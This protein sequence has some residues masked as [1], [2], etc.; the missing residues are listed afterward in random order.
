MDVD[1]FLHDLQA[2]P[3]YAG[4][5]VRVYRQEPRTTRLAATPPEFAPLLER[6]GMDALYSHQAEALAQVLAGRDLVIATGTASGKSLCYQLPLLRELARDPH[7]SA[8]L[9]F[10]T[11]ALCQDQFRAFA[12]L[13]DRAGTA[14]LAGVIDG[15]TPAEL[16]RK[17]RD[18]GRVLFSNPDML[19]AAIMPQH[20]RWARFLGQLRL[21]VLDEL[22]VYN[23][24]FGA[25]MA[26]L[27][28]RLFRLCRH[29]GA[30]PRLIAASATIANARELA[31]R[32]AGRPFALVDQDGSP[33]GGRTYVFWNPPHWRDTPYRS[34]RSAN[35]EA[36]ELMT[37][38]IARG[39]PTITF[40]KARVTAEMIYRYVRD[41]LRTQAP[42]LAERITPYRG[43]YLP[44]ERREIERR[45]FAGELLGVSSTPALE[46]GI[47]VGALEACILVG[48]PGTRASFFQQAGRAGRRH[49]DALVFLV[50]LDTSVNQYVQSHPEYLFERSVEEAVADPANPCVGLAHLRCACFEL[51]LAES[52]LELFAPHGALLARLLE[53]NRKLHHR[54][55]KYYYAAPETPHHELSLRGFSDGNV[56]LQDVDSG[57]SLGEVDRY[58]APPLVH[59]GAIYLQHDLSYRVEELDLER[60]LARLKRVE[61]DYYTQPLGGTDVHHI[62]HQLRERPFGSGRACWGE[63][64]AYFGTYAYEKIRFYELDAL[65][66]HPVKLPVLPLETSALWLVPP[67]DLL[68]ELRRDGLDA[69]AALRGIGYATRMLL[70]LFI[71]CDTLDLSHSV[72]SVN[73][74][75]QAVFIYERY[76]LGLGFAERAYERLGEIL[77]AVLANVRQC[78]CTD[79]CPCCT[80]KPL[81]QFTSWNVERGEAQIPNK[82]ATLRLL[83]GF[84]GD[85]SRLHE[86]DTLALSDAPEA[87]R[88]RLAAIL[89]RRLERAR[90][91]AVFHPILPAPQ[92][93]TGLPP[94]EPAATLA[95]ADV[96]RRGQQ[97]RA[98]ERDLHHRL[99]AKVGL[100]G[101]SPKTPRPPPPP[102]MSTPFGVVPPNHP[103]F[104]TASQSGRPPPDAEAPRS[105]SQTAG[106]GERRTPDAALPQQD[107][108]TPPPIKAGDS[109]AARARLLR[110]KSQP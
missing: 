27:L 32:L 40:S 8:L 37:R 35:V 60:N 71:T 9:L 76:P 84:L 30:A 57:L 19:H 5:I 48:Y 53:E 39:I 17:L 80:G 91:P 3:D 34:R 92:V 110:R 47:D 49:A 16:R 64:T 51:A 45:L 38:L 77:P 70:P 15:D 7:A 28:R 85:G 24:V 105:P 82:A 21:L 59:P 12:R 73:S 90:E 108:G 88:E 14:A 11:K 67:E 10:P 93:Q 29:Y 20:G 101:L 86:P 106:A 69:H 31:E 78:P 100:D 74:P 50:G 25:N 104:Q 62:D 97:R 96:E 63:V 26:L 55:G 75:W 46:L 23:G 1:A 99:A 41:A 65:S 56:V 81:R 42:A 83:A 66:V 52:E 54:A 68:E 6:L 18:E 89:R 43:G 87:A 109:L 107:G 61:T 94:V 103:D 33:R 36:H 102:G 79:G 58:D 72:G 13:Q 95:Q 4:Q 98:F 44:A 22:H 2:H